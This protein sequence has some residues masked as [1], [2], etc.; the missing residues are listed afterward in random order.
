MASL[1]LHLFGIA[2][3]GKSLLFDALTE[4]PQGPSFVRK[5]EV[6]IGSARVP[7]SRLIHLRHLF[8]PK[9]FAPAEIAFM[10][11]EP[12]QKGSAGAFLA[13]A[14]AFIFVIKAFGQQESTPKLAD[15][16]GQLET[17]VLDLI[18]RDLER[19]ERRQQ[20]AEKEKHSGVALSLLESRWL[21]RCQKRLESGLPLL[22]MEFTPEEEAVA[23]PYAFL[24]RK[25]IIVAANVAEDNLE[26]L[27]LESL[28]ARCAE[29]GVECLPLCAP[30]EAEISK[31]EPDERP[32]FLAGYG[33]QAPAK[34]RLIRAA[35]RILNLISFFTVGEDEVKAWTLRR[36]ASAQ[37][38]AGKIHSDIERGFIRAEVVSFE[39][40]R[41]T[42]SLPACRGRHTL[43]LEGREYRV[44]D[45]EIVHFRFH[46]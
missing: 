14:D 26:G 8:K 31:I 32:S 20:R 9:K 16:A 38:A 7:D 2:G 40:F 19:I 18:L 43:R 42:G 10:D 45:G 34:D 27:G 6:R 13:E 11:P 35:Y 3:S 41:T 17:L 4:T 37:N 25:P 5:K 39:D 22:G 28:A 30:L 33:L 46:V 15:P 36:G 21:N 12:R 24:S 29:I 44:K 1:S 23:R